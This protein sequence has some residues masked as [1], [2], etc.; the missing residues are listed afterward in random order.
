[1]TTLLN[2]IFKFKSL[3]ADS[4]N[5]T[6]ADYN[7]SVSPIYEFL[8]TFGPYLIGVLTGVAVIYCVVL[9]VG[10]AKA[11]ESKDREVAK[12]KL[13]SAAI[14]FG[15]VILLIV[16]LYALRGTFVELMNK[17]D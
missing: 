11:E 8:D 1:M 5:T 16:L 15:L 13:I 17:N 2:M 6:D 12:K 9:G 3:L 7:S 14:S 4:A 10:Y